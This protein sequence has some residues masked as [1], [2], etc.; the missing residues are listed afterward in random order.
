MQDPER[1][2]ALCVAAVVVFGP[3]VLIYLRYRGEIRAAR[4]RLQR[5]G[6]QLVETACGPV[7]Y[8]ALGAGP[9]VLV[10]HGL[11]GGYDQGLVFARRNLGEGFHAIVPSRFGYLRTPLPDGA[12]PAR[13]ADAHAALLDALAIDKAAVVGTS[14][15][16]TSALQ[17]ALR[18]PERCSALILVSSNAPGKT[19]D[20][21]WPEGLA[22]IVFRSDL[23]FWLM[24]V[25]LRPALRSTMGVPEKFKL[26]PEFEADLAEMTAAMLPAEPRSAGALF[27]TFVSNPDL[28]TGYPLEAFAVPV[29]I[30]SAIDDPLAPH[31]N[32][33]ALAERIPGA[34]LVPIENGGAMLLGHG[35]Q[36]RA[37]IMAF[38]RDNA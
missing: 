10:A 16:G 32:A 37:E 33:Q 20:D 28:N 21:P 31:R 35:E 29:L 15:G 27:D 25:V 3:A 30:V 36:V 26:T 19:N 38:L 13:Q 34:R 7:E 2:L 14:A 4:E 1:W 5:G 18:H 6:S 11:Y 23:L 17:F 24:T 8:A 22:G 12:S 9:A